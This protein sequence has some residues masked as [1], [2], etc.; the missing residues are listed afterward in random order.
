MRIVTWNINSV[1]LRIDLLHQLIMKHQPDIIT[2]QETKTPDDQF[3]IKTIQNMGYPYIGFRG[4]KS[5]NG[6]AII[7]KIAFQQ[8]TYQLFAHKNDTRHISITL[9]NGYMIHNFYIPAGGDIA[10]ASLNEKFAHKLQFLDEMTDYFHQFHST[11]NHI[12]CGDF[13]IAPHEHDVW[14]H[15]ALLNVVSHTP[16]EVEKLL[17]FQTTH[18]FIDVTRHIHGFD[19]KIYSWW[20]YRN[21]NWRQSN[22]GRRLDHIWVSQPL[23]KFVRHIQ[24]DD[25]MRDWAKPSDHVAVIMD[26]EHS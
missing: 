18:Q 10:D 15:K 16:I 2:L 22:R 24:H 26:I 25:A 8:Q 6:V 4:E 9:D 1:R 14:S 13:N 19:S 12:I 7:S 5:Y 17:Q 11:Q 20:S 3:P 23:G 21:K